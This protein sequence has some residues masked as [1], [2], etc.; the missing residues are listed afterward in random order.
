MI[1]P[2]KKADT[3]TRY[4]SEFKGL[5]RLPVGSE[6]ELLE[7]KNMVFDKYP[8]M[9]VRGGRTLFATT[10]TGHT[11]QAL[12]FVNND[13]YMILDN[14]FYKNGV[15][16]FTDEQ[17]NWFSGGIKSVVEF[18]GKIFIFP[19]RKVYDI[20]E[21][22][23]T[24]IGEGE[25]PAAGSCPKMDYV[26][27]HNNRI[28]GVRGNYIYASSSGYAM[29]A[30][31]SDGRYGWTQFYDAAGNPD[32]SGSFF[33]EVASDGDFTG[34]MSWDD[35]IIALK[36][37]CH[38][39]INGS[40]PS[41]FALSTISKLGTVS[42]HSMAE[43]NGRAFYASQSGVYIY[44]GGY[45]KEIGRKLN[46][47]IK[48]AVAG[49]DGNRYYLRLSNGTENKLYVY[50][51]AV[52]M[53]TEE[54]LTNVAFF[55]YQNGSL[56]AC[57]TDGKIWIMNDPAS[58]ETVEWRFKFTDYADSVYYNT[59]LKRL[60]FKWKSTKGN[61]IKVK[62]STD[63]KT[64][65]T[66]TDFRFV[67]EEMQT[68]KCNVNRGREHVIVVEGKGDIDVYGYQLT[69]MKGGQNIV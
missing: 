40:Y 33:Q 67:G 34:I 8:V 66:L 64:F 56:Y 3:Y 69:V 7:T 59:E 57:C 23:L 37:R 14:R 39:E 15:K 27:V 24:D 11:P 54:D 25:Y 55:T 45:E 30:A 53:W 28:W 20:A 60:I 44:A 52:E 16:V 4:I 46:E 29:G 58:T 2:D 51:T 62:I 63:G 17:S 19:D 31:G 13:Y 35:R 48:K 43:V 5:N 68:V 61:T 50:H 6:G 36:E 12:I 49:S 21:G 65:R 38:H 1:L 47:N 10:S 32:D 9:S 22:T 18:W 42:H 41:T 26:C